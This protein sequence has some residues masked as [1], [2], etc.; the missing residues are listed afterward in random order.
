VPS[1]LFTLE[2]V[3]PSLIEN[4]YRGPPIR[5]DAVHI[6]PALDRIELM[7][8]IAPGEFEVSDVDH[9]AAPLG[10]VTRQALSADLIA[11]LPPGRVIFPHLAKPA[12]A[13]G[14]TVDVIVFGANRESAQLQASWMGNSGGSESSACG[15]TAVLKATLSGA[16]PLAIAS[17]F[18]VL[19]AQLADD[20]AA[21]LTEGRQSC[22]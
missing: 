5:I 8:E 19:V 13:I 15:G 10:Q 21:D 18:S 7:T 17:A 11:R 9:W 14:I 1:R 16:G 4:A 20:I 22:F 3:M 2:P 12:G 6:P